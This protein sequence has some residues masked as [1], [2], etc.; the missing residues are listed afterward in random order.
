MTQGI[1]VRA[2]DERVLERDVARAEDKI[3]WVDDEG[4]WECEADEDR[5]PV[6]EPVCLFKHGLELDPAYIYYVGGYGDIRRSLRKKPS[7][8]PLHLPVP[9]LPSWRASTNADGRRAVEIFTFGYWGWGSETTRLLELTA[10]VER[11][12][13]FEAPCFVDLRVSRSVRAEGFRERSFEQLAGPD[14]YRWM[15]ELGNK[16]VADHGE[17]IEIVDPR[18]AETLLDLAIERGARRQR[19]IMFCACE[20][21]GTSAD[22]GC[23]RRVV[24]DLLI[25]AGKR[26]SV[27]VVAGEWPGGAPLDI[28]AEVSV[29]EL[30]RLRDSATTLKTDLPDTVLAG[31]P[32]GSRVTARAGEYGYTFVSGPAR[33]S[34]GR[35]VLPKLAWGGEDLAKWWRELDLECGVAWP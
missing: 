24:A 10:A 26:R 23:H 15:P 28:E 22:P 19:V 14:R 5:Q 11:E 30:F 8:Q 35:L 17:G 25:A 34:R 2:I 16:R 32:W 3:Y 12:R 13:G 1:G 33:M 18:A 6:G 29:D 31:L 9:S 27:P 7:V 4:V 20:W 21:P